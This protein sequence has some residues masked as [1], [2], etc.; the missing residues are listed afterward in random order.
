MRSFFLGLLCGVL[1][2]LA[3]LFGWIRSVSDGR[4]LEITEDLRRAQDAERTAL[5]RVDEIQQ[6]NSRIEEEQRR[7][8]DRIIALEAEVSRRARAYVDLEQSIEASR[9]G[10]ESSS[11]LIGE[12]GEILKR[13]AIFDE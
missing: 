12:L 8:L 1:A 11:G 9:I 2:C 13:A 7:S 6:L 5:Q 3:I 4:L 10:I